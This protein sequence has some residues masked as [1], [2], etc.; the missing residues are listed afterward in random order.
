M[1]EVDNYE[2]IELIKKNYGNYVNANTKKMIE[3]H[4]FNTN[5]VIVSMLLSIASAV[6]YGITKMILCI[7]LIPVFLCAG[8]YFSYQR[9]K[10]S[11]KIVHAVNTAINRS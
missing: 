4:D 6:L 1:I 8:L 9:K 5:G 3:K 2:A 7:C 10:L 11:K